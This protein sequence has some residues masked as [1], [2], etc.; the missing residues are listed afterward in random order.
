MINRN[1]LKELITLFKCVYFHHF[2]FPS[3]LATS[4]IRGKFPSPSPTA[5]IVGSSLK[6]V[7]YSTITGAD[8]LEMEKRE[9]REREQEL[10]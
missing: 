10:R 3:F 5:P 7:D 4:S 9:A 2:F 6:S 1:K 8:R